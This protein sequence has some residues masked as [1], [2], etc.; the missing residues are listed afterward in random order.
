MVF[1]SNIIEL[2]LSSTLFKYFHY[3]IYDKNNNFFKYGT[4]FDGFDIEQF[5]EPL[6][7]YNTIKNF[8]IDLRYFSSLYLYT[9]LFAK[10]DYSKSINQKTENYI[11]DFIDIN[12]ITA[13]ICSNFN[14][15]EYKEYLLNEEVK[16]WNIQNLLYYSKIDVPNDKALINYIS[17][18]YCICLPLYCLKDNNQNF[19]P[20]N[21]DY[22]G[23][24]SLPE[25]CLNHLKYFEIDNY[26]KEARRKL[27]EY[28]DKIN[29]FSNNLIENLEYEYYSYK[30]MNLTIFSGI[31]FL[32]VNLIDNSVLNNLLEIFLENITIFE[33]FCLLGLTFAFFILIVIANYILI[34]NIKKISN[35]IFEFQD[36]HVFYLYQFKTENENTPEKNN[37]IDNNICNRDE[38]IF[39]YSENR[40]LL[41]SENEND[42]LDEYNNDDIYNNLNDNPLLDDLFKIYYK[43]YNITEEDLQKQFK[44]NDLSNTLKAKINIIQEKNE[45]FQLLSILSLCA[46]QFKLNSSMD[47]N[48]NIK[49]KLNQNFLKFVKK[50]KT[51]PIQQ[52]QLTQSVIYELMSAE[53]IED[54]GL[55]PNINFKYISNIN[56]KKN[57]SNSIKRAIFRYKENK[58]EE[59]KDNNINN[60]VIMKEDEDNKIKIKVMYKERNSLLDELEN[61][62][63]NDDF[64]K[65]E[66]LEY[67]FDFFLLNIY[68][69]YFNKIISNES[70]QKKD[71]L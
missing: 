24:I 41:Q 3:G 33:F 12:N 42:I 54:Y 15:S 47:Y 9:L 64:L 50:N 39:N 37:E 27:S 40:P 4:S 1:T 55:L 53:N 10:T 48:F 31:N 60:K 29:I 22:G 34:K 21:A 28:G 65:K 13:N 23:N 69:K 58:N 17:M 18:P 57:S 5:A 61:N 25:K 44:K 32:I 70:S 43:Y 36:R 6:N 63:E 51:M 46:P 14:Y 59:K 45:L 68:Y 2:S 62:F 16:C 26:K 66:K 7:Y 19:N 71:N 52:A 35:T 49:S 30:Y 8:N 20:S 67:S 38:I 56:L 11:Y